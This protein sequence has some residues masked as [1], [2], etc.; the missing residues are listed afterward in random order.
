[1]VQRSERN[2]R[3]LSASAACGRSVTC[4]SM[5]AIT[6]PITSAK[7]SFGLV[8]FSVPDPANTAATTTRILRSITTL[9]HHAYLRL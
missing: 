8:Q 7:A 3:R 1:M 2:S 6:T 9:S 4:A 5:L